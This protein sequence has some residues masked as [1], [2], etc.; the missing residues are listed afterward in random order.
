MKDN[1]CCKETQSNR[2][3]AKNKG[4]ILTQAHILQVRQAKK[5]WER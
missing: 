5:E 1:I 2:H 4:N 3:A